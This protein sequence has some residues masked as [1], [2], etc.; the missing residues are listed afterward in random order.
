MYSGV[1]LVVVIITIVIFS[2]FDRLC[3]ALACAA[4]DLSVLLDEAPKKALR[5]KMQEETAER[6]LVRGKQ[7]V[8]TD[9]YKTCTL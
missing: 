6:F 8:V 7:K 4:F 2:A 9:G 1:L 5:T 3:A